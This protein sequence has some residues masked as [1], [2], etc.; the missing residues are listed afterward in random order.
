MTGEDGANG[1]CALKAGVHSI[2]HLPGIFGGDDGVADATARRAAAS[3]PVVLANLMVCSLRPSTSHAF[4]VGA[5]ERF[6]SG[7][8]PA[9][10]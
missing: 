9:R 4:C 5:L 7:F 10:G 8:G 1:G 3:R 6:R 2:W